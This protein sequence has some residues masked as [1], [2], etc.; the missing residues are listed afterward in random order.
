VSAIREKVRFYPDAL[1]PDP[2]RN[3]GKTSGP[4]ALVFRNRA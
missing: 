4:P 3:L 1:G 2:R